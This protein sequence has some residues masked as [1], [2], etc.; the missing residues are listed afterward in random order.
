IGNAVKFTQGQHPARIHVCMKNHEQDFV[1]CVRDNGVGFNM[2]Q[3]DRLFGM[4]QRLHPAEDFSG[5]GMGLALVRRLVHRHGGRAWAESTPGQGATFYFA[6]PRQPD[7][8]RDG[9]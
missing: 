4:F 8:L 2:R 5:V 6:L 7:L 9:C 1:V 3:K